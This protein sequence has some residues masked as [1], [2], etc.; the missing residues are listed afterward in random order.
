MRRG[1]SDPEASTLGTAYVLSVMRYAGY[2]PDHPSVADG[3]AYLARQANRRN[4][5]WAT[6]H[7]V[8]T[9]LGLSE[10]Q[11]DAIRDVAP[12]GHTDLADDAKR[13]IQRSVKW[14]GD[15]RRDEGGWPSVPSDRAHTC[16]AWTASALYALAR[17]RERG[18]PYRDN[19]Q[20]R[21]LIT[22]GR[23]WLL[24]LHQ[25][26]QPRGATWPRCARTE[27]SVAN[28]ALAVLALSHRYL[29]DGSADDDVA[30][31]LAV[32]GRDALLDSSA[33]W[34]RNEAGEDDAEADD[35]WQ[36]VVWS[37]APRACLSAGAAPHD[38]R[39]SRALRHAFD[40][41]GDRPE[42]G[43]FIKGVG[44]TAYAN[45]SV[46]QLGQVLRLAI[47][48]QDPLKVVEALASAG[49]H[50]NDEGAVILL[51]RSNR[52]AEIGMTGR[53]K[54]ALNLAGSE[55]RW[56]LLAA[57]ADAGRRE[58]AGPLLDHAINQPTRGDRSWGPLK[59]LCH[60]LN[61]DVRKAF[62][63]PSITVLSCT[64][65]PPERRVIMHADCRFRSATEPPEPLD[66][67]SAPG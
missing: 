38:P 31:Q 59:A 36:H 48:R 15:H 1:E 5:H 53:P 8:H 57:F 66:I 43:W 34:S 25:T 19:R 35:G 23:S 32:A 41:W 52:T 54:H 22:D 60:A 63:E 4:P 33:N 47:S 14:L 28:T 62:D 21:D 11:L 64:T 42:G 65:A 58:L 2:Q 40:R 30:S 12:P 26:E 55:K 67:S 3:L 49:D 50:R 18:Y 13:A 51:D 17:L 44:K 10:W 39:L 56:R 20:I 45:W 6:R 37:L 27:V 16:V 7:A 24:G 9:I 29:R 61:E 46:V